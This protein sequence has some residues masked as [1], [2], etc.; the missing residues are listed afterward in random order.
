M[1]VDNADD[2]DASV[3]GRSPDLCSKLRCGTL[4]LYAILG[5][6]VLASAH[7]GIRANSLSKRRNGQRK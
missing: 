2:S 7:V 3:P 6:P 5:R 1:V 4:Y